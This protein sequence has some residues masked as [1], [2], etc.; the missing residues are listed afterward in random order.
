MVLPQFAHYGSPCFEFF[1]NTT[2][3]HR[4]LVHEGWWFWSDWGFW[5]CSEEL[6]FF[7]VGSIGELVALHFLHLRA[8]SVNWSSWLTDVMVS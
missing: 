2:E 1:V 8:T 7:R 5:S 3:N 4:N 6:V